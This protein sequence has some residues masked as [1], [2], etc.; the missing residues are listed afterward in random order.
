MSEE[1][2]R[3][4]LITIPTLRHEEEIEEGLAIVEKQL[5]D[6]TVRTSDRGIFKARAKESSDPADGVFKALLD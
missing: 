3:R 6:R 5:Q 4:R 1:T 2:G